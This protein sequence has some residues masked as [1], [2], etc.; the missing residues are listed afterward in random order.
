MRRAQV[1]ITNMPMRRPCLSAMLVIAAMLAACASS[2]NRAPTRELLDEASGSTLL[3]VERPIVFARARTDVAA[4]AR[5]YVTMVAT[6]EDRSGKFSTWLIVHRWSTVDP[7][8][9]GPMRGRSGELRII[10][11]DRELV[12]NAVAPEPSFLQ[13]REGLFQP[14]S[15]GAQSSA[16]AV[17]A[18]TLHFIASAHTLSLRYSDDPLLIPYAV[19]EDGRP[20]LQAWLADTGVR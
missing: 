17:D 19:W 11:D 20:A 2:A 16:Y 18:P 12:L 1:G 14:A 10:A 9:A 8:Y 6:H 13:R 3:I 5:D 7:R 4:N 15:A